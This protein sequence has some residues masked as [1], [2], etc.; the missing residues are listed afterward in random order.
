MI[1]SGTHSKVFLG[2]Y[3]KMPVAVKEFLDQDSFCREF[4]FYEKVKSYGPHP[5]LLNVMGYL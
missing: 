1:G 2:S 3:F 4:K 5:N